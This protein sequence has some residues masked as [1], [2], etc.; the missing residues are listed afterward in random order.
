MWSMSSAR[1]RIDAWMDP[2]ELEL[3]QWVEM[4]LFVVDCVVDRLIDLPVQ[5][6]SW[7]S[8]PLHALRQA[9]DRMISEDHVTDELIFARS[10]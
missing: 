1:R 2:A 6:H 8:R 7:V 5:V 4:G 10:L 9:F 3:A